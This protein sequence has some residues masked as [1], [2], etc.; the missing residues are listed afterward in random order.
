MSIKLEQLEDS[1]LISHFRTHNDGR[2]LGVLFQRHKHLVLGVCLK[3]LKNKEE[4]EDAVM[5]IFEK[6]HLDLKKNDVS[7]FKSWLYMVS[8]NYC[9]MQLRKAGLKVDFPEK[10]PEMT[11]NTEGVADMHLEKEKM[12]TLLESSL[13]HL[14]SEQ[15][16]CLE[17]FYLK[18]MSYKEITMETGF[19]LNEVKT[20]IQNGKLN[21]KKILAKV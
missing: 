21:L 7:H 4:A 6:L 5:E 19:A 8:K 10:M 17:L 18:D 14:K 9:L 16:L 20:H 15:K 13:A 2:A 1:A 3:Y 12:L 11:E